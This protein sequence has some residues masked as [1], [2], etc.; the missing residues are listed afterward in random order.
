[1]GI[2][3]NQDPSLF[4]MMLHHLLPQNSQKSKRNLRTTDNSNNNN[5]NR[6][7]SLDRDEPITLHNMQLELARVY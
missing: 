3:K 4:L 5:R 6:E 1:M 2:R 7:D